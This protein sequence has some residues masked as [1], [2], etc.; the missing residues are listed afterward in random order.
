MR[1][2]VKAWA[3]QQPLHEGKCRGLSIPVTSV[4]HV[5]GL[6]SWTPS[7]GGKGSPLVSSATFLLEQEYHMGINPLVIL[8]SSLHK[9]CNK[10]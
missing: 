6:V 7:A 4:A 2:S 10:Q 5:M 3:A 8:P 1:V 9:Q